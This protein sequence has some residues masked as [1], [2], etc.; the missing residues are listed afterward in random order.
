[1]RVLVVKPHNKTPYELFRGRTP[2]LSFMKPFGCH[3]A[4]LNTLDHLEKFNGNSDEGFFVGYSL[5]SKAF[6]VYNLRTRKVEENLHIRFLEDKPSIVGNGPKWLFDIDDDNGVNKDSEI[7]DHEKSANSI[8]DI[9]TL[10]PSINT[11]STNFDTGSLNFNNV[12][13]TVSAGSPEA[14]LV[15]FLGK[16][17][18]GTKWV[19]RNKND[20]RGIMIKNKARLV[21]QGYTQEEGIDYDEVFAPVARIEAIRLLLA[22]ASFMGFMVYQMDVKSDFIYGMIEEEVYVCQ[23]LRFEDPDHLDKVYK[24]VKELYGLH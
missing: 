17:A 7:D 20:K 5:N 12:S 13:L 24:V 19:F 15:D 9:N 21:A 18:I 2:T 23:P 14:T 1:N 16:K 3:V 6:R 11:A 10:G 8:N 4:I 22:Y